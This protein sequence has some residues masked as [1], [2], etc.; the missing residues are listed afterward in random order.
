[1]YPSLKNGIMFQQ[2]PNDPSIFK[3]NFGVAF[4]LKHAD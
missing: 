4:H 3:Y 1:M 2:Y